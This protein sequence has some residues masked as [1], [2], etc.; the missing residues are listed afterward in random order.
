MFSAVDVETPSGPVHYPAP[1]VRWE[2]RQDSFGAVPALGR[3]TQES[4]EEFKP[5]DGTFRGR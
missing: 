5:A 3:H 4:R 2:G 1:P